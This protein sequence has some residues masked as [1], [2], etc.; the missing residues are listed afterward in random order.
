MTLKIVGSEQTYSWLYRRLSRD[1]ILITGDSEA[2]TRL[3][4]EVYTP[5]TFKNADFEA[6]FI[7][8]SSLFIGRKRPELKNLLQLKDDPEAWKSLFALILHPMAGNS[9]IAETEHFRPGIDR[10]RYLEDWIRRL[11]ESLGITFEGG[12]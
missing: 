10:E 4:Y 1:W 8:G 9:L 11:L 2:L 7:P 6:V 12:D 5:N 3:E